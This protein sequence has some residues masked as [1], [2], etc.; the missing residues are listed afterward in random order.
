MAGHQ[1]TRVPPDQDDGLVREVVVNLREEKGRQQRGGQPG[2]AFGQ[3]SCCSH[4]CHF[5]SH[6]PNHVLQ[7]LQHSHPT[8]VVQQVGGNGDDL[9]GGIKEESV[10]K[11]QRQE[12]AASPRESGL[13]VSLPGFASSY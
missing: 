2:D 9:Q 1:G 7:A 11:A 10:R 13:S 6:C 8:A 12:C 4:L 3:Q 5:A